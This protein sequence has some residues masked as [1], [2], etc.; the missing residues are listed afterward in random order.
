MRAMSDF[1]AATIVTTHASANGC[2][3][4]SAWPVKPTRGAILRNRRGL[5]AEVGDDLYI[6][7]YAQSPIRPS[8]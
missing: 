3:T 7:Q 2:S 1:D 4:A 5:L 6:A 8:R